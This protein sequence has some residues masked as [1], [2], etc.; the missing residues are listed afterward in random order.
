VGALETVKRFRRVSSG[1]Q[2]G[3]GAVSAGPA[4]GGIIC[5]GR[6]RERFGARTSRAGART[7]AG[8]RRLGELDAEDVTSRGPG[9]AHLDGFDLHASVRVPTNDRVRLE[10]LAGS[11]PAQTIL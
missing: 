10:R 3:D 11:A 4:R 1:D 6:H 2:H 8:V 7:G 5:F 9:Q